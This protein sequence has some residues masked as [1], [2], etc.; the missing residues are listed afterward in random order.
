MGRTPPGFKIPVDGDQNVSCLFAA[1]IQASV[2]ARDVRYRDWRYPR[3]R[4]RRGNARPDRCSSTGTTRRCALTHQTVDEMDRDRIASTAID[5]PE[6]QIGLSREVSSLSKPRM[7]QCVRCSGRFFRKVPGL[8]RFGLPVC[9]SSRQSRVHRFG[10]QLPLCGPAFTDPSGTTECFGRMTRH[11]EGTG[12][13]RRR[14]PP[15]GL[16]AIRPLVSEA[17]TVYLGPDYIGT[18]KTH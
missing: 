14:D 6:F 7:R 10:G 12:C 13:R 15:S 5:F 8:I 3:I 4:L 1:K 18:P 17:R 2:F 16:T 9:S 11:P